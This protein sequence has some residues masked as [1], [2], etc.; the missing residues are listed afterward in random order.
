MFLKE[1]EVDDCR[2]FKTI[3]ICQAGLIMEV[4]LFSSFLVV[5]LSFQNHE[6]Y[7][8]ITDHVSAALSASPIT[9]VS[10]DKLCVACQGGP[11][12]SPGNTWKSSADSRLF[13]IR[14]LLLNS[15]CL[16]SS[17]LRIKTTMES[18]WLTY[19][20]KHF[21]NLIYKHF[22]SPAPQMWLFAVLKYS[23]LAAALLV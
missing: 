16:S 6:E 19:K 12:P 4:L 18:S 9:P 1:Y 7:I 22:F 20:A 15:Y 14:N 10:I 5:Y 2:I 17:F 8:K 11:K 23:D 13:N 21:K 3:C